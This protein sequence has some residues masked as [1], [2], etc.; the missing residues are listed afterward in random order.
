[1]RTIGQDS[2]LNEKSENKEEQN[3]INY[4]IIILFKRLNL[5]FKFASAREDFWTVKCVK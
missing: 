1:M 5:L 3:G 2:S 4:K